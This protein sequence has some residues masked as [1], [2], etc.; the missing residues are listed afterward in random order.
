MA[1]ALSKVA[2]VKCDPTKKLLKV[3]F[4]AMGGLGI[5]KLYLLSTRTLD[6]SDFSTMRQWSHAP[7]L[8][9]FFTGVPEV[10]EFE[11]EMQA[12]IRGIVN[13][14]A[15]SEDNGFVLD[16]T[17]GKQLSAL[18]HLQAYGMVSHCDA[19][20]GREEW[21]LTSLGESSLE[22]CASLTDSKLVFDTDGEDIE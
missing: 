16:P 10:Q 6:V 1:L 12:T 7:E 22:C 18:Q 15:K 17:Q 14:R 4:E 11:G 20:Q 3:A 13:A 19:G 9:Y 2:I 5:D 21:R 8:E